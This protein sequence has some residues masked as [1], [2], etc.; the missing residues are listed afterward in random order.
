MRSSL[1]RL[2]LTA[3]SLL[4][5]AAPAA[6]APAGAWYAVQLHAHS[7]YSDGRHSPEE[8]VS[9]A[10]AGG[11]DALALSEH[12][13]NDHLSDPVFAR[14]DVLVIPAMEWT[15]H[16][17]GPNAEH[18]HANLWGLKP[19]T[20]LLRS[21]MACG[22]MAER[23]AAQGLVVG[24]NHPFEPRF[25]WPDDSYGGVHAMEVW[26]WHYHGDTALDTP[27]ADAALRAQHHSWGDF[28]VRNGRAIADWHRLLASGRRI[29]PVAV[30]DFH[31]AVAQNI[32]SPCTL[33][34]ARERSVPALLE[35]LKAGRVLLVEHP[36][37]TRV[38]LTADADGDGK[39]ESVPGDDVPVGAKLRLSVTRGAG[40]TLK[41]TDATGAAKTLR[42]EGEAWSRELVAEKS[43]FYWARLD[44]GWPL[45]TL[46]AMTGALY[47]K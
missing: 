39:F 7:T 42:V 26:H 2:A 29:A 28:W 23:A 15:S 37:G 30:S 25:P 6:A 44:K 13:M 35:G 43:G 31:V 38:E 9:W 5:M 1:Q 14:E 18:G 40:M 10:K 22:E 27:I 19:E 12:N 33:V 4:A 46:A 45:T 36:R 34:W 17:H 20:P 8:L 11:L 24:V 21:D 16:G 47:V 32:E 41:L 3:A